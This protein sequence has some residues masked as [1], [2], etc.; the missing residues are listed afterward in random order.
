MGDHDE[1]FAV[2]DESMDA[3]QMVYREFQDKKPVMEI[4]LPEQRLYAC[5]YKEY[6]K[7]LTPRDQRMLRQLYRAALKKNCMVVFVKDDERRTL[8]STAVPIS[9]STETA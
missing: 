5:P 1:F 2:L 3:L 6:L 8:N 7:T 9:E 4:R